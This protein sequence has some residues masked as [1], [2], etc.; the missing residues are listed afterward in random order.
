MKKRSKKSLSHNILVWM[1]ITSILPLVFFGLFSVFYISDMSLKQIEN[2]V[3]DSLTTSVELI[4]GFIAEYNTK[5]DVLS[6]NQRLID[7]LSKSVI[8]ESE[9]N[10]VYKMLYETIENQTSNLSIY[11]VKKDASFSIGTGDIPL[12]YDIGL[13]KN[14]GVFYLLENQKVPSMIPHAYSENGHDNSMTIARRMVLNDET[15]AYLILDVSKKKIESLVSNVK[16][17]SYGLVQLVMVSQTN[18]V[19]YNDSIFGNSLGF[20]NSMFTYDRF[21]V[22]RLQFGFEALENMYM[23]SVNSKE[24]DYRI[25]GIV[26]VNLI[27][28]Y[29]KQMVYTILML[30]VIAALLSF[31][32]RDIIKKQLETPII[33]LVNHM[34]LVGKGKDTETVVDGSRIE[35]LSFIISGYNKMIRRIRDLHKDDLE[36]QDKLRISEIKTLQSQI[37]PHFLYNTLDTIKWKAKFEGVQEIADIATELGNI[38]K[39]TMD[40]DQTFV[41][42][43]QEINFIKSYFNIMKT[44]YADRMEYMVEVD[45]ELHK[46]MMP[47]LLIQ[48]LVENAFEHGIDTMVEKGV[49]RVSVTCN[50]G[51][52]IDVMNNGSPFKIKKEDFF[53]SNEGNHIGLKNIEDRIKLNYNEGYGLTWFEKDGWMV[54]RITLPFND[55][56]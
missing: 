20:Y 19:L 37:N 35:E 22:N 39:V 8:S 10:L 50:E 4:D 15:I 23:N 2:R 30:V 27:I 5:V 1:L 16:R 21:S 24:N 46:L 26:P 45:C 29:N 7:I 25:Y 54:F 32:A 55:E 17:T 43:E 41:T 42:L 34:K 18:N 48:P 12:Q 33:E 13:F 38:L 47:K 56:E 9:K 14:W 51:V 28:D 52:V 40:T 11:L 31:I 49:I 44:R 53:R 3:N 6:E 36:K